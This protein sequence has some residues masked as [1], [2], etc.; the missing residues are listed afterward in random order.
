MQSML[1]PAMKRTVAVLTMFDLA[2]FGA[3][4]TPR[5]PDLMEPKLLTFC[6]DRGMMVCGFEEIDGQRFYQGWWIQWEAER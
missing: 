3:V 4:Q 2:H 5:I 1:H 6:S